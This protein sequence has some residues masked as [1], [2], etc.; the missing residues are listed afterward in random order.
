MHA[1][2]NAFSTSTYYP[3]ANKTMLYFGAAHNLL[4]LYKPDD[5]QN[6]DKH[7]LSTQ[8][9]ESKL[10]VMKIPMANLLS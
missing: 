2:Q 10:S 1:F 4:H 6:D 9:E 7:S 3:I 8:N 5:P